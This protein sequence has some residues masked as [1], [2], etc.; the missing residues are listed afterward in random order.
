MDVVQLAQAI[1][2]KKNPSDSLVRK[3]KVQF[4]RKLRKELSEVEI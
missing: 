1:H 3:R 2:L 4:G